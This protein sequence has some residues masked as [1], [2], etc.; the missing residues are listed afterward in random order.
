MREIGGYIELDTYSF[1]MLHE[2]A[3]ALNCGR[4]CLAYLIETNNIKKIHLPFFLCSSVENICKQYNVAI[5]YYHVDKNFLP[6]INFEVQDDE[7]VYV[8]NYYGQIENDK[9]FELKNKYSHLI[10]DNAQAYFQLPVEDVDTIYTCRKF[11][12][13]A[14]GAFLYTDK[15]KCEAVERDY[16]FERM[17]FLLG[18]YEKGANEFY[19]EYVENNRQF[20]NAPILGMSKLTQNLLR[21]IDYSRVEQCRT[22]NFAVL[23]ELLK[24]YNTLELKLPTGAFMYPLC[25]K[26]GA[27]IR[28]K[29]R[30]KKIYIPTLWPDV[31]EKCDETTLEYDMAANILPIPVDQRYNRNDMKYIVEVIEKC[32]K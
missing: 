11:F 32:I 8:V 13:V 4:N 28:S 26:N 18:R 12:G 7:Y 27:E 24:S 6:N 15:K 14:D 20:D 17:H 5:Q 29:C 21:G 22:E 30:E 9:I 1:P 19:S 16:S 3:V 31:F 25:I 10:V 23:D 2:E